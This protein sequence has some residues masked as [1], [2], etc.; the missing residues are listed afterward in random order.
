[1][2]CLS[3]F[4]TVDK[5]M[6]IPNFYLSLLLKE[7]NIK[8]WT[9]YRT[10]IFTWEQILLEPACAIKIKIFLSEKWSHER[11]YAAPFCGSFFFLRRQ[12]TAD[13]GSPLKGRAD[14][15]GTAT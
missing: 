15:V 13:A 1:M 9:I 7:E 11:I 14:E 4:K 2:N 3:Q 12:G 10:T 5:K 6:Y 8:T